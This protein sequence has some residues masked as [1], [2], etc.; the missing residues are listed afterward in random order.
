MQSNQPV[1]PPGP[2]AAA[3][4]FKNEAEL[5]QHTECPHALF[6]G[7]ACNGPACGFW[8]AIDI[9][10]MGPI[11]AARVVCNATRRPKPMGMLRAEEGGAHAE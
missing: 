9:D 3:R 11:R 4:E 1:L 6:D 5:M 7:T 2:R 8:Q 10:A